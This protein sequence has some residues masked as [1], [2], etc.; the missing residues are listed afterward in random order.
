MPINCQA[1]IKTTRLLHTAHDLLHDTL[2]PP[3]YS[4]PE[5]YINTVEIAIYLAIMANSVDITLAHGR[6]TM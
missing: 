4:H 6:I 2:L 3:S 5:L 1:L